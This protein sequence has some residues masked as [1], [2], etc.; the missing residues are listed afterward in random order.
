MRENEEKEKAMT[1]RTEEEFLATL[2]PEQLAK[3]NQTEEDL[4]AL[5]PTEKFNSLSTDEKWDWLLKN[6]PGYDNS[7]WFESNYTPEEEAY[8][9]PTN[10][11]ENC[12]SCC[13]LCNGS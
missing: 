3:R 4:E 9:E 8:Y 10:C 7:L 5:M 12:P 2:T 11:D 1:I 6:D 13:G